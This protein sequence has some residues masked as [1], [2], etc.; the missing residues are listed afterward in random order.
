MSI[1]TWVDG[2][3]QSTLDV[4]DRAVQYGD[5]FFTTMLAA[6][7]QLYN[8]PAHWRRLSASVVRLGFPEIEEQTVLQQ[9]RQA[10]TGNL[11]PIVVKVIVSRGL[12]GIGYQPPVEAKPRIIIQASPHPTYKKASD[13]TEMHPAM[14]VAL[15]ESICAINPQLAGMKHLN[16]LENV[17]ARAE[18]AG[19]AFS[20]GIMLNARQKVISATQS[21]VFLIKG[22]RLITPALVESGVEGTTRHQLRFLSESLGL[23]WI[24]CEITL[25]EIRNADELFLSNAVRG[26]MPVKEF[27]DMK[28]AVERVVEI[29]QAWS[30]WQQN[31]AIRIWE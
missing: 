16:R 26:I 12:G 10:L 15:C 30:Q 21:N 28:F 20:E 2:Q 13:M 5:G 24:E 31:N 25:D 19:T 18:L 3:V 7:G 6:E 14:A 29:Q 11:Q 4:L 23:E 9:L 22:T 8:W 17:L 27:M 1:Q